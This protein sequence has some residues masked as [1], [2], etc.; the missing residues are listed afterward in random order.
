MAGPSPSSSGAVGQDQLL[1]PRSRDPRLE[2]FPNPSK[3]REN[4]NPAALGSEKLWPEGKQEPA[5]KLLSETKRGEA[6][7]YGL[8]N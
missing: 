6:P 5:C 1:D 3:A 7:Y 4:A 8:G 2:K